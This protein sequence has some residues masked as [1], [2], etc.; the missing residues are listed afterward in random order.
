MNLEERLVE[1]SKH[2]NL[3]AVK[4]LVK[5]RADIHA[6][7]DVA[8]YWAS[9]E[10]HSEVVKYL[11]EVGADIHACGDDAL[12]SASLHGRLEV[13]EY[14]VE[15]YVER[16]GVAWCL[17]CELEELREYTRRLLTNTDIC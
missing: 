4:K 5:S 12:R 11:C 8:L 17:T 2:G 15:V 9:I 14:L 13:I 3:E 10:G 6:E 16:Y 1:V 7:E